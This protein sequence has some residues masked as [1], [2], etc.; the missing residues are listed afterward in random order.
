M[1]PSQQIA[2]EMVANCID[3]LWAEE[4]SVGGDKLTILGSIPLTQLIE[5][6]RAASEMLEELQ[7][8]GSGDLDYKWE[9]AIEAL[10]QTGKADWL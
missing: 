10:K 3:N 7:S 8:F 1:K 4:A 6:A 9:D 2:E 5:V